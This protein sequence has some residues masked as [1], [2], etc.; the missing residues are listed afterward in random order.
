[1]EHFDDVVLVTDVRFAEVAMSLRGILESYRLIVHFVRLVQRRQCEAFFSGVDRPSAELTILASHGLTTDDGEPCLWFECVDNPS[2]DPKATS[3]WV[4]DR[5]DLTPTTIPKYV[6]DMQ[7]SVVSVAC[8]GGREP[9]ARAFLAAGADA[10]VGATEPYIDMGSAVLFVT[11]L[12][13]YLL[14][15][16]RDFAPRG[17][18]FDEAVQR[19]SEFD[20]DWAGGTGSFRVWR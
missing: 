16:D 1:M 6:R 14:A 8:G 11:G 12:V 15:G 17:Y 10:Y 18:T 3:G 9:L 19:A 2:P 5:F 13:Y 4:P 20:A 7:G